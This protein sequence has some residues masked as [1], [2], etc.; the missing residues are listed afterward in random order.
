[1]DLLILCYIGKSLPDYT[2]LFYL[3]K[4]EKNDK[5]NTK[6]FLITNKVKMKKIYCAICSVAK[7]DGHWFICSWAFVL[8]LLLKKI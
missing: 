4:Y 5:N 6:I 8:S 2:N 3:N 7:P 1:M